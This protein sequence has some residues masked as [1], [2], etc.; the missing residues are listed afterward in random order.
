M[1]PSRRAR[2]DPAAGDLRRTG[3]RRPGDHRRHARP[4]AAPARA[5]ATAR[6]LVRAD[7][8]K[9]AGSST[10]ACRFIAKAP[11]TITPPSSWRIQALAFKAIRRLYPDY[12]LWRDFGYEYEFD[13]L[14]IDLINGSPLLRE[15]VDS[16]SASQP[17]RRPGQADE[18]AWL[19]T[20]SRFCCTDKA[21]RQN[22]PIMPFP[23]SFRARWKHIPASG[24]ASPPHSRAA[25]VGCLFLLWAL[26]IGLY[27]H[28]HVAQMREQMTNVALAG[29]RNMF[30]MVILTR[31]W[32]ASH[33]GIYVPVTQR[34]EPNPYLD[35][36]QR[37]L[38]TTDG[39]ALTMVNPAYMTRLIADMAESASGAIFRLTSLEADPPGKQGGC[40]GRAKSLHAFENGITETF[41]VAEGRDGMMLRYMARC[42]SRKAAWTATAGRATR[43]ATSGRHQRLATLRADRRPCAATAMPSCWL[44][45]P[46][47]CWFPLLGWLLLELLRRRW[48]EL[49]GKVH[50][51]EET[52]SQLLQSERWPPSASWRP[53]SRT[54]STTDRL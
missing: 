20:R 23:G 3:Y 12:P 42:R 45:A 47:S 5:A 36:P 14:A 7:F 4:G 6:N 11:I 35:H 31:N 48:L 15:W 25:V 18:A 19:E 39:V 27:T 44:P 43:S 29:A 38:T 54:R 16:P 33:G 21:P 41:A 46:P 1:R 24:A 8:H 49:A 13:R 2:H 30:R 9:H 26:A 10:T 53:A 32:N 34:V 28:V 22:L 40:L 50:E 51:L 52:Q 37:D 17:T